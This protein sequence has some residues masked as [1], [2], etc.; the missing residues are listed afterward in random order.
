MEAAYAHLLLGDAKEVKQL[1]ARALAAPDLET[2]FADSPWYARGA[3]DMGTSYRLDLA[4]AELSLGER[5]EAER[6]LDR[7]LTMVNR[8]IASGV[9]RYAT[10]ELRAKAYALKGRGDDAMRDLNKAAALGWRGVW[11]ARHQPYLA[12]LESR[13]DYQAL[14]A[15]VAASNERLIERVQSD[16]AL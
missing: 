9:E 12:G 2:G 3:R 4:A 16:P 15:R 11:W 13:S 1:M 5:A 10:Y 7:V 6:E 8:M 14:L